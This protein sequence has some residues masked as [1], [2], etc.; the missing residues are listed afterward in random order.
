MQTAAA[1][2]FSERCGAKVLQSLQVF[3]F[4]FTLV[5]GPGR[6]LSLKLS[7]V[8]PGALRLV[9]WAWGMG[10]GVRDLGAALCGVRCAVRSLGVAL[11]AVCEHVGG[12]L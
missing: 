8:S 11:C 12:E 9:F 4:F 10:F 1:V 3:F 2:A 5:T 7:D 6:S